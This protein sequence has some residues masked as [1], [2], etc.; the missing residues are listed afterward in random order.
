MSNPTPSEALL[1]AQ[2]AIGYVEASAEVG[3]SPNVEQFFVGIAPKLAAHVIAREAQVKD[4][5]AFL[6]KV[7][8]SDQR[9]IVETASGAYPVIAGHEDGQIAK[10]ARE[11]K[12]R[13]LEGL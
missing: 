7:I 3:I 6:D 13:L 11:H 5:V 8:A 4:T 1:L 9:P 2:E 12:R 10:E